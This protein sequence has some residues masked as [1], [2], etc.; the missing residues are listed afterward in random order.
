MSEPGNTPMPGR[1]EPTLGRRLSQGKPERQSVVILPPLKGG[2]FAMRPRQLVAGFTWL[3]PKDAARGRAAAMEMAL[4]P[5]F[6]ADLVTVRETALF[7]QFGL[8]WVPRDGV[9]KQT[10]RAGL[11]SPWTAGA[12]A[13]AEAVA[14]PRWLGVWPVETPE[15][16]R[17]WF[18]GVN[19]EEL[20]SDGDIIYPTEDAATDR[21]VAEMQDLGRDGTEVFAPAGW[22]IAGARTESLA[23]LLAKVSGPLVA[24]V[25]ARRAQWSKYAVAVGSAATFSVGLYFMMDRVLSPKPETMVASKPAVAP[26]PPPPSETV[27]TAPPVPIVPDPGPRPAAW[28]SECLSSLSKAVRPAP[29]WTFRDI[30]CGGASAFANLNAEPDAQR[31]LL[32]RSFPAGMVAIGADGRNASVSVPVSM[33]PVFPISVAWSEGAA[34]DWAASLRDRTG[35]AVEMKARTA[36]VPD[37]S[38]GSPSIQK[39]LGTPE[40]P[41]TFRTLEF[42]IS[43]P[44]SPGHWAQWLDSV[45]GL[46]L[47][48]VKAGLVNNILGNWTIEGVI[49]VER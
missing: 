47:T 14:E 41:I 27:I 5:E 10:L 22:E 48:G 18:V 9:A 7:E 3:M 45:P 31:D 4:K 44:L 39:I 20:L 13:L 43:S 28:L 26:L 12:A 8:G 25:Q 11:F 32:K 46:V 49:Y 29:G 38:L 2:R 34:R 16:L 24:P 37:P 36:P 35:L 40:R 30:G 42:S 17:W 21:L 23:D 6:S 33:P 1:V 15:G 19:A